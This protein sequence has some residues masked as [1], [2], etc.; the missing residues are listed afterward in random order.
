MRVV[1]IGSGNAAHV[2]GKKIKEADHEIIQVVSRNLSH[3]EELADALDSESG[4]LDGVTANGEIYLLAISDSALPDFHQKLQLKHGIALHA[5]G[6]VSIK[7]LEKI[8]PNHGVLYP[9]QS[10]R[11][12]MQHTPEIPLLVDGNTPETLKLVEDF[13]ETIS[14]KV[15][16]ANDEQRLKLHIA[17]VIANNFINHLYTLTQSFC[18]KEKVDFSMLEPLIIETSERLM[19]YSPEKLQTGPAMRNDLDTINRHLEVLAA[20][21][22]LQKIYAFFSNNIQQFYSS[23]NS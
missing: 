2:L 10:L 6:S 18:R 12:E 4:S 16:R 17:A 15:M 23:T 13:A 19:N 3:A 8:S 7:V 14:S 5:A 9:L 1:I 22:S 20:Y 11:A 21:P